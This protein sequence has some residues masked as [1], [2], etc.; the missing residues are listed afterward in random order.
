MKP[1]IPI[2]RVIILVCG[3]SLATAIA[4]YDSWLP[5]RWHTHNDP[6]GAFS[7]ELPASPVVKTTQAASA[8]GESITINLISADPNDRASYTCA[9][10]DDDSIGGESPDE[11]LTSARDGS[12]RKTQGTIISQKRIVVSGYPALETQANARG[13]SLLDSR[14]VV[15]GNRLYMIA[16]VATSP[17]EREAKAVQRF[18][19]SFRLLRKKDTP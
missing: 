9:D 13:G 18:M 8:S 16:A 7:L 14:I 12:L 3:V 17:G 2:L 11:A 6:N 10:F 1:G 5:H 19:D 4:H 15:A